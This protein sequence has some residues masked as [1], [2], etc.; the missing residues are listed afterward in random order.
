MAQLFPFRALRPAPSTN[1]PP[2]SRLCRLRRRQHRG[3]TRARD[4]RAAELSARDAIR[5]RSAARHE[6]VCDDRVYAQGRREFRRAQGRRTHGDGRRAVALSL[7]AAHG[8]ARASWSGGMFF[9]RRIRSRPDQE[10]RKDPPGQRGRPHA[11]RHRSARANRRGVSDVP[12]VRC[13]ERS[14]RPASRP[15]T[16]LYGFVAGRHLARIVARRR[17]ATPTRSCTRSPS[18]RRCTSRTDTIARR[19]RRARAPPMRSAAARQNR[20]VH[21][22][23]VS[24][25]GD[26]DPAMQPRGE[27]SGGPDAG[28]AISRGA[29]GAR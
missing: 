10:A 17:R 1:P 24:G 25:F 18:C 16:P 12:R 13:G 14:S 11:T 9:R 28:I 27:G 4:K 19:A 6:S 8:V 26:A 22:R 20:D 23:G 21:R 15:A 29:E 7:S 2:A 5:S 3:S